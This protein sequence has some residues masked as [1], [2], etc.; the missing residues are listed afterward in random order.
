[1]S[2]SPEN[3][4]VR[5]CAKHWQTMVLAGT[6]YL[7]DKSL[8]AIIQTIYTGSLTSPR[9]GARLTDSNFLSKVKKLG[10]EAGSNS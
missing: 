3:M 7:K 10:R 4:R 6:C 1:M 5:E 2:G 9:P 8:S